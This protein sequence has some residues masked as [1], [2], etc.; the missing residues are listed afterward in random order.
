MKKLLDKFSARIEDSSIGSFSAKVSNFAA[1]HPEIFCLSILALACLIFLFFGLNLYPLID[2]DETKYAVI[3]RDLAFSGDWNNLN[4]NNVPFLDASPLYFWIVAGSIKLWGGISAFAV[5]FPI[6]LLSSGLV[7]YTYYIGKRVI[8]RKFGMLSALVLL[9][10]LFFIV[11]AHVAVLDMVSTVVITSAIYSGLLTHF[12]KDRNKK[13]YWWYFY[14]FVGL[15]ALSKGLI[16][17]LIPIAVMLTYNLLTK[18]A[19][20][21]FKPINLIPGVIIGLAIAAPW[22]ILMYQQYGAKFITE[23]LTA[24]QASRLSVASYL[25]IFLLGLFPWSF[26]FFAVINDGLENIA[27]KY[28]KAP[29]IKQKKLDALFEAK[30]NEE[31][32][33]IFS[34]I[35]FVIVMLISALSSTLM[36][37]LPVLPAIALLTGYFWWISEKNNNNNVEIS[38]VTQIFA[39]VLMISAFVASISF[40][41]LPPDVQVGLVKFK[42][43]FIIGL[44]LLGIFLLLRLNTKKVLPV[45]SGYIVIMLFIMTLSVCHVFNFIYSTGENELVL[46]SKIAQSADTSLITFDFD[47]KPSVMIN[48]TSSVNFLTKPDFKLLN[49]L[50]SI[51]NKPVIVIVKNT[52]MTSGVGY[53]DKINSLLRPVRIGDNYSLYFKGTKKEF[54]YV[55]LMAFS[56]T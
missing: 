27:T 3:A 14:M 18:T 32:M 53:Q 4:L 8:S 35:Y 28:K 11:L 30:T 24:H 6:A 38:L 41:Y 44:Y 40:S 52:N 56:Q 49:K 45:F 23:Y 9:S 46:Y 47:M 19:K 31:K 25:Y 37:M 7:F 1:V 39:A 36:S 13:F 2:V 26:I 54:Q 43:F 55:N 10:S 33:I 21:M 50:V 17:I 48:Y 16:G 22:H 12:C 42:Y 5:R 51:D 34:S 20:D 29:G 15:A